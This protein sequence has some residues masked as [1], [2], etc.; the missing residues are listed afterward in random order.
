MDGMFHVI[1]CEGQVV[2]G[3]RHVSDCFGWKTFFRLLGVEGI[4]HIA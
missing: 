2:W 4:M 3:V 1:W